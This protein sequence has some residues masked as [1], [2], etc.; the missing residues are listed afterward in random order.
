MREDLKPITVIGVIGL[1]TAIKLQEK[2][3]YQVTILAEVFASDPPSPR[4]TSHWAGGHY[5]TAEKTDDIGQRKM[6]TET[7]RELWKL[8]EKGNSAET[9]FIRTPQQDHYFEGVPGSLE[10]NET[11]PDFKPIPEC[12]LLPGA[13]FGISF[14]IINFDPPAYLNYLQQRFI[15]CGGK[16]VRGSVQHITQVVE[17]GSAVFEGEPPLP[18]AAIVVCVGLGARTLG[19]VEDKSVTPVGGQTVIIHAPWV[20]FGATARKIENGVLSYLIPRP[21]GNLVI[22][23]T[24]NVDDWYP[25]PRAKTKI[26]I[27]EKALTFWP[28]I[29]PPEIRKKRTPTVE[30]L[31]PIFVGDGLGMRPS[32]SD[33]IRLEVEWFEANQIRVPIVFQY[34][35]GGSGFESSWGSASIAVD[36]MGKALQ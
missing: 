21:N 11:T 25:A 19:G 1:T 20:R 24:F 5:S 22:G 7:F 34:G 3:G 26:A 33:G 4:Y 2:G 14:T 8:S 12:D 32:R 17:G 30:D 16:L 31:I 29:A 15:Q 23:G 13:K 6:N 35:H 27:M 18:P 9:C 10:E 28:D 36:L